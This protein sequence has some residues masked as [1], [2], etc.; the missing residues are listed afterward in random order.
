MEKVMAADAAVNILIASQQTS[1]RDA[2]PLKTKLQHYP[3][4][5]LRHV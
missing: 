5:L 3:S 2:R 4:V 1:L